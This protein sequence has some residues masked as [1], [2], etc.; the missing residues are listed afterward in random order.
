MLAPVTHI[1]PLTTIRRERVLPVPGRVTVRLDQKVNP[2]DVVAEANYG[3]EHILIDIA[4]MLG[5]RSSQAQRLVQVKAGDMVS[6]GDVIARQTGLGGQIIHAPNSGRVIIAAAGRILMEVGNKAFELQA[7]IPGTISRQISDRGVEIKFNGALV[8]GVWGN[9]QINFGLLLPVLSSPE[10]SLV[11][12][13]LDI[14]QRGSVLLAGSC[15][16]PA[17]LQTAGDLPVRGLI[18]GSMSPALI[19][20]AMQAHYPILVVDG[21]GQRPLNGAAYKLLT[22]NA[23]R[24]TALNAEAYDRQTGTRPEILISLPVTDDLPP[25]RDVETFAPDQVVRSTHGSH[26]GEVG[27]LVSLHP[28]LMPLPNGLRVPAADVRLDS[29]E[30]VLIPLANLE[31]LG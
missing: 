17:A 22:T 9:G 2:L 31:V 11:A 23:R 20:L 13:Q 15:S 21:F 10:E 3:A 25:Q 24:E 28:G 27:S 6:E 19:P 12:K 29:G 16:D 14:S 7:G 18:L 4:R 1:L 8:Q 30:Q 26:A 5:M